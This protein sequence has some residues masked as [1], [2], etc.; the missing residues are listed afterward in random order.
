LRTQALD[1]LRADLALWSK[2]AEGD[3]PRDRAAV[4]EQLKHWQ[5]DADLAG[6]RDRGA[7]GKL[8]AE[9]QKEWRHLWDD[10]SAVL[11]RAS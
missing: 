9:E 2:R 6:L 1:W 4:Q 10:V 5:T 7:L 3:D 11:K 8:L